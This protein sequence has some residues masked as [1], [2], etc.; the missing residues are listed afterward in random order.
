M[1]FWFLALVVSASLGVA[2]AQTPSAGSSSSAQA[3]ASSP[4]QDSS[5]SAPVSSSPASSA[6]K[7][8]PPNSAPPRSGRVNAADLGDNPGESS[9]KDTQVDLSPPVNDEKSHPQSE[10]ML[11][12]AEASAG[13]GDV[14]ETHLWNPHRAAKDIEVGDFYFKRKNYRA[15]EDRYR[16]A[17]EYKEN[18]ATATFRLAESLEKMVRREEA[19]QEYESY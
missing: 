1:R 17:L 10:G 9:S 14:S 19:R 7:M 8:P 5:Q 13:S 18:D 16:E 4:A 15:A 12:D 2:A 6:S 11:K 3:P